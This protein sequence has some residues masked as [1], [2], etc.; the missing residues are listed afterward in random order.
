MRAQARVKHLRGGHRTVRV[1]ERRVGE[2]WLGATTLW[3]VP[4]RATT[5]MINRSFLSTAQVELCGLD[6][7]GE[8]PKGIWRSQREFTV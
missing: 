7:A 8:R 3:C 2:D 5:A 1:A 6:D 4:C